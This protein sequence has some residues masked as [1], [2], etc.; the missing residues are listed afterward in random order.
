MV[1]KNQLL[2]VVNSFEPQSH[3]GHKEI[4]KYKFV[5]SFTLCLLVFFVAWWFKKI[6]HHL[7][8]NTDWNGMNRRAHFADQGRIFFDSITYHDHVG[9]CLAIEVRFFGI[10]DASTDYKRK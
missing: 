1:F 4:T 9:A 10:G 3:E 7:K 2:P 8:L 5:Q 6:F